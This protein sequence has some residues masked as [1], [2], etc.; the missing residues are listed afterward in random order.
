MDFNLRLD[1]FSLGQS[2]TD[3]R[4]LGSRWSL[5]ESAALIIGRE[6][7]RPE[8]SRGSLSLGRPLYSLSTPWSVSSSVAWNVE[9]NR[10]YRGA[11]VW[12]LPYPDGPPVPDRLGAPPRAR[13]AHGLGRP[14][15]DWSGWA[16]VA[17]LLGV[18]AG[19]L[20]VLLGW[21]P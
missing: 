12:Q 5:S 18:V 2:Y 3:P 10:V 21:R 9:T 19:C 14:G 1:T 7:G 20:W 6:S 4:L 8:G 17:A 11:E 16:A 13:R 15:T